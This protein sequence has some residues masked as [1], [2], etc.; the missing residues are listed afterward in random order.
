MSTSTTS[1]NMTEQ[2]GFN[3]AGLAAMSLVA[4]NVGLLI[5]YF[6]LD[7]TLFQLVLIYW[8]EILWIGI[9]SGLKLLTASLFGDP[10][11]NRL[12][13]LSRGANLL[14]SL[15]AIAKSAGL[16]FT[17]L[18]FTGVGL[19][20]GYETLT[21]T[22]GD[23]FALNNLGLVLRCS[24]I[25]AAG[26]GLSFLINFLALGEFRH[27]RFTTLLGL[28]FKRSIALILAIAVL[29]VATQASPGLLSERSFAAIL[30]VAKLMGDFFLHKRERRSLSTRPSIDPSKQHAPS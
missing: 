24:L 4:A 8:W 19:A 3:A 25:F 1:S 28:P 5:L 23:K 10:Y 9:F 13:H 6:A 7:L 29:L 12:V 27:A 17:L 18:I 21:G 22:P 15:F 14:L 30:I 11:E 2:P 26:H 16:F 20:A